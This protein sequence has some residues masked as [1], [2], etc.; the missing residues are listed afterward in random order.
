[1]HHLE[2]I[3]W[4]VKALKKVCRRALFVESQVYF[5]PRDSFFKWVY[6]WFNRRVIEPKDVIYRFIPKTCGISGFKF[7]TNYSDGSASGFSLVTVPSPETIQMTLEANGFCNVEILSMGAHYRAAIRSRLRDFSASCIFAS[8]GEGSGIPQKISSFILAYERDMTLAPLSKRTNALLQRLHLKKAGL[9]DALVMA[10]LGSRKPFVF[11]FLAV[12]VLWFYANTK[13]QSEILSNF[14]FSVSD[15]LRFET[16]KLFYHAGDIP[17]ASDILKTLVSKPNTDWR[18][19]YR[20]FA[21]LAMASRRVADEAGYQKYAG[22]CLLANADY[23]LSSIAS[24][25]ETGNP[26]QC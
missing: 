24:L 15:K 13:V 11:K 3:D 23:P 8:I 4:G 14:K 12:P 20:A 18:V 9:W 22:L 16:A 5:S 7:E 26:T 10:L 21:L 19:S 17:A 25:L 1:M 2:N 6:D